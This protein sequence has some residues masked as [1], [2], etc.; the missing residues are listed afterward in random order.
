MESVSPELLEILVCPETH[1]KLR[2]A[3]EPLLARLRAR[4]GEGRLLN[5]AGKPIPE[6]PHDALVREDNLFAY[7][8]I[9][10]IPVMLIEEAIPLDQLEA[11]RS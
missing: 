10:A 11:G 9:D 1:Q 5:R 6:A 8:V 2:R 3:D 4:Q 7:L